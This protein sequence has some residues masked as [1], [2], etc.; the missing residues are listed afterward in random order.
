MFTLN[1]LQLV[2]LAGVG[3]I[4]ASVSAIATVAIIDKLAAWWL[5]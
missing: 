2:V 3:A 5:K 4:L 1:Y